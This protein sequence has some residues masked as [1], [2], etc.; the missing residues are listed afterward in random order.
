MSFLI[1]HADE[2]AL[3]NVKNAPDRLENILAFM[4]TSMNIA[5][6]QACFK[7]TNVNV[8][9]SLATRI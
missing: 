9:R 8:K 2:A 6:E 3:T 7:L 4:V 1:S 5:R